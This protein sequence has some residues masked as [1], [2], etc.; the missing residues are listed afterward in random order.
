[1]LDAN[2]GLPKGITPNGEL[3]TLHLFGGPDGAGPGTG[4]VRG[5]DG[6]FNGTAGSGGAGNTGTV[7]KLTIQ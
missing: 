6:N 7:F 5:S 4:V 2:T 1:V 3:T